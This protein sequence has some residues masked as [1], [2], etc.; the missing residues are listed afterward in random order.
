MA[1]NINNNFHILNR[2]S[3]HPDVSVGW[4]WELEVV[5]LT[6]LIPTISAEGLKTRIKDA[7]MP[8]ATINEIELKYMGTS[9]F[10]AGKKTPVTDMTT[11]FV[12]TE[13]GYIY[14]AFQSWMT[15]IQN[16]SP[17]DSEGSGS[18]MMASKRNGY[19]RDL[20][21]TKYTYDGAIARTIKFWNAW[22]KSLDGGA[23]AY[24]SEGAVEFGVQ[25]KFDGYEILS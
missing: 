5:N 8:G 13:D 24:D 4:M 22:P 10:F 11:N 23:L 12:E 9:Q 21:L 16:I 2:Q 25:W 17:W 18:S 6:S 1:N 7:I 3:D 15:L 14:S 20:V 19:A